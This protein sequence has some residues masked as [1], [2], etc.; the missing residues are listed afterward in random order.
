MFDLHIQFKQLKQQI[1]NLQQKIK[2]GNCVSNSEITLPTKSIPVS[3]LVPVYNVEFYLEKCLNS[4]IS[5][6][7]KNIEIICIND[8]STDNSLNILKSYAEKDKR[9]RIID[10][11]NT[12]YGHSLN[13]GLDAARG[14]YIGIIESDDFIDPNM[15]ETLYNIAI[16]QDV[17]VVISN[18]MRHVDGIDFHGADI[19]KGFNEKYIT[20]KDTLT[21]LTNVGNLW[22]NI[23]KRVFLNKNGIRFNETPGA[24]YQDTSFLFQIWASLKR[25]YYINKSFVHYRL[26]NVDSSTKS[27][28]R[29]FCICDE[30]KKI[31]NFL[32]E[33]KEAGDKLKFSVEFFKFNAY[34]WNFAR[35]NLDWNSKIKFLDRVSIEFDELGKKGL[36][37]EKYW[38]PQS[39]NNLQL[40]LKNPNQYIYLNYMAEQKKLFM[41]EGIKNKLRQF[42]YITVYGMD[43]TSQQIVIMLRLSGIFVSSFA[44]NSLENLPNS[45]MNIPVKEIKNLKSKK[46]YSLIIVPILSEQRK[47]IIRELCSMGFENLI[48]VDMEILNYLMDD[49]LKK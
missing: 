48:L 32:N 42:S 34:M 41:R 23:Y 12:G 26:D 14:E 15:F 16:K 22:M 47:A 28:G 31:E 44:V 45:F 8:G 46:K 10:K 27:G 39:W 24:A 21:L 36:L 30:Y 9:I 6:S 2:G 5:Q 33:H 43:G 4:I 13:V 49:R 20:D 38:S 11:K 3:I 40:L 37:Q 19:L 18:F 29:L 1:A 17:E 25:G 7:L 35:P